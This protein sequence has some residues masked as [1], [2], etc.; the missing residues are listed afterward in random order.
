MSELD[1]RS[2]KAQVGV[3]VW[4]ILCACKKASRLKDL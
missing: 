1:E 3:G 2:R 4:G